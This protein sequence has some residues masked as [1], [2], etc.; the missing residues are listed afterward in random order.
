MTILQVEK[1]DQGT[2]VRLPEGYEVARM[3]LTSDAR[4]KRKLHLE[5]SDTGETTMDVVLAVFK[6]A[7][8]MGDLPF[9]N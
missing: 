4:G 9:I 1:T 2:V 3:H 7:K 5:V 8:S 6:Y